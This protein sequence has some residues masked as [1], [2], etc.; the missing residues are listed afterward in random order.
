MVLL[1][2]TAGI[3]LAT[4]RAAAELGAAVVV[5]SS[6]KSSA[7]S[8]LAVLPSNAEGR[9]LD[10]RDEAAITAF[11]AGIGPFDHLVFTAG[12]SLFV[13]PLGT[14]DIG[15]ARAFFEIR[16]WAAVTSVKHAAPLLRPGGSITLTSG[17]TV[18]RPAPGWTV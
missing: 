11:F 9:V 14:T 18:E 3:G 8:A 1:G 12:E 13:G 7:D 15:V 17:G 5:A 6:R 10:L 16:F 4:A 2:G